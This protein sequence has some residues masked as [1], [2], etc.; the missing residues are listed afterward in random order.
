M[1]VKEAT[2]VISTFT[3]D[4]LIGAVAREVSILNEFPLQTANLITLGLISHVVQLGYTS[5]FKHHTALPCGLYV[6]S[7]QSKAASK[8]PLFDAIKGGV[9]DY[10][11]EWNKKI[12]AD[13]NKA[14]AEF[15]KCDVSQIPEIALQDMN[16]DPVKIFVTNTT[17]EALEQYAG[18]QGGIFSVASTE[19]TILS[20]LFGNMYAEAGSQNLELPLS[21][22]VGERPKVLR[23]SRDG[24]QCRASGAIT[25]LSQPGTVSSILSASGNTGLSERFL[26]LIEPRI[27][28]AELKKIWK[29]E[30]PTG[31]PFLKTL[32]SVMKKIIDKVKQQEGLEIK[33]RTALKFN[34]QSEQLLEEHR[35]WCKLKAFDEH[36]PFS[37]ELI[38]GYLLKSDLQIMKVATVIHVIESLINGKEV[39]QVIEHR[40]VELAK[41]IVYCLVAGIPKICEEVGLIGD[42]SLIEV[43]CDYLKGKGRK[44]E[45]AIY[46]TV[47]KHDKFLAIPAG[48]RRDKFLKA[49][50]D[51]VQ[52]G[53][54]R[55]TATLSHDNSKAKEVF[56]V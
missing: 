5:V 41:C 30:K 49:M 17:P 1:E 3:E 28:E 48:Q 47:R 4:L 23:I 43:I 6:V 55:K 46:N 2:S 38:V 21:G 36:D 37:N 14:N 29:Q 16:R 19:K 22:F 7:E 35:Q 8:S 33:D 20:V 50:S 56:S 39:P 54:I 11:D 27:G 53:N 51:A 26:A 52:R 34:K 42:D 13:R 15:A 25:I 24:V 9:D 18:K 32:D 31:R 45:K 44:D 40:Y 12:I 10:V